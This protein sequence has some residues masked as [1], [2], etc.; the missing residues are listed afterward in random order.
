MDV[1]ARIDDYLTKRDWRVRENSN[2]AFS[3]QGLNQH[4]SGAASAAYWLERVYTPAIREAHVGGDFHLHDLNSL[5]VYCMGWDLEDLLLHGF[6]GV[7]GQIASRPPK[8]FRTAL[9]QVVNFFYTLQGE[10]AGA[11][12]FSNF[13]TY[14]APFIAYDGLSYE[15]VKQAMQ[16]FIFNLNVPT[17]VGFQTPFTN[18]T[19][20]LVVPPML[21]EER[22]IIGGRRTDRVYGEFQ[23]EM[24]M[25]N[26]AFAEVMMEGDAAGRVFTFPIPTYNVTPDFP[27]DSPVVEAILAMTAKYGTPYFSNFINTDMR[28]EDAR[29]MCCRLRLD[30][31]ELRRRGGGLFGAH[32]LT[33]SIGVVTLNLPRLAYRATSPEA[34][35]G[36]LERLLEL[37]K[38][39]LERKR[40]ALERWMAAGLYPY[41]RHYLRHLAPAG[42][43]GDG[44]D[45]GVGTG[46][47]VGSGGGAPGLFLALTEPEAGGRPVGG[48]ESGGYFQ[49]HFSTIGVIGMHEALLNLGLPSLL[50]PEGVA[51]AAR[52]LDFIRERLQDFQAETGNLYN[53]EASP[54]EG[55][56][57]RLARIDRSRY[58]DI[59]T[60]GTPEAPYY[61]NS[62][63]LPVGATDDLFEQIAL[64]EPL[65]EKY[66]GGTVFHI[67]LGEALPD[68]RTAGKLL[69][70]VLETTRLPYVTLTPTF[71]VCD[72]HGYLPGEVPTCPHCGRPTEVYSRVVG[73]YRP[74]RRWN[75]GKRQE[76][77][78]RLVF[79][80]EL[81]ASAR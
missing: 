9:L 75:D 18:L 39:S 8:H 44:A 54:A 42:D 68:G 71:S 65:Q 30:N 50:E 33:G 53:L 4:L 37:A 17:R 79:R 31:R 74:V 5:S 12:A 57:Y 27:W 47:G 46:P 66:T 62:T 25:L 70:T 10:A 1:L 45:A 72:A 35:F 63:Q 56:S 11:Q 38:D 80:P 55:A 19:F 14:L 13:D 78:E 51:F 34:F 23:R 7:P 22:V 21:R 16:E 6:G 28:P 3:L 67:F 73:Y 52:V 61:T 58:P 64:E 77:A 15:D 32:P 20:D 29:S 24:D 26:R 48:R 41:T 60:S 59:V 2:M 69:R 40:A 43:P 49:N 76:F 36:G 81:P